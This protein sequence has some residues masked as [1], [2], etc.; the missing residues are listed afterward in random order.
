MGAVNSRACGTYDSMCPYVLQNPLAHLTA[1]G[2]RRRSHRE[3]GILRVAG[4]QVLYE[5]RLAHACLQ[6]TDD[7]MGAPIPTSRDVFIQD[8]NCH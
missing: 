3:V 7:Q 2:A 8:P 1:C 5:R 6:D 4:E